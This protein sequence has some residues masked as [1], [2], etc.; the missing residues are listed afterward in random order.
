MLRIE[1]VLDLSKEEDRE[2]LI[3]AA[4]DD[5]NLRGLLDDNLADYCAYFPGD[6]WR[7]VYSGGMLSIRVAEKLQLGYEI[8]ELV[9]LT[10]AMKR[11]KNFEGF[12]N[13]RAGLENPMQIA[14][15]LFEI[16]VA[17][18]CRG[19]RIST[20]LAFAPEIIVKERVKRP[21]FVWH[22]TLGSCVCECKKANFL[23]SAFNSRL[24]RMTEL[25]HRSY[26]RYQ[27]WD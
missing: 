14:S 4:S 18:W 20:G 8:K 17:D 3:A 24:S 9:E 19:R 21:E 2:E 27:D 16:R 5:A 1:R 7:R 10:A 13:L 15:T 11:L 25:L 12:E 26:G 23:Q 22:T 6:D